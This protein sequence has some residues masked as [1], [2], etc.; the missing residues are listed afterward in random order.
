[1]EDICLV[2]NSA[3]SYAFQVDNGVPI[4]PFYDD[5]S[6]QE[7]HHLMYYLDCLADVEDV[8]VLNRDAFG[9]RAL[10]EEPLVEQQ[11]VSPANEQESEPD[12]SCKTPTASKEAK[13]DLEAVMR[14]IFVN[15]IDED[16]IIFEDKD[17]S[18]DQTASPGLSMGKQRT[19]NML[20]RT[21]DEDK[22][23]L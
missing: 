10:A 21:Q 7:I 8:R 22:P 11:I 19:T 16:D 13:T 17:E 23:Q 6:D 15:M 20:N 14:N 5:K 12:R 1:M 18:R 4:V 9:L 2:D 3:Y